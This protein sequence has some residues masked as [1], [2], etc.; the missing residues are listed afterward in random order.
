MEEVVSKL[1]RLERHLRVCKFAIGLMGIL[2]A[3]L[4]GGEYVLLRAARTV[5]AG[6]IPRRI[7]AHEFVV[8]DDQN[9]PVGF[10][11]GLNSTGAALLI[12]DGLRNLPSSALPTTGKAAD[13]FARNLAS[14]PVLIFSAET[15]DAYFHMSGKPN[16]KVSSSISLSAARSSS[17]EIDNAENAAS[18]RASADTSGADL[19]LNV[20]DLWTDMSATVG[21]LSRP[22]RDLASASIRLYK[23]GKTI[24][25]PGELQLETH[26]NGDTTFKMDASDAELNFHDRMELDAPA[27]SNPAFRLLIS[28]RRD[29]QTIRTIRRTTLCALR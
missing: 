29:L 28:V 4:A 24:D 19:Y 14:W 9:Q 12:G 26:E 17:L 5:G 10:F 1:A 11:G 15:D 23:F 8:L 25:T 3:A 6:G 7:E 27:N 18:I 22:N 13:E 16:P 21:L 20:G 2:I